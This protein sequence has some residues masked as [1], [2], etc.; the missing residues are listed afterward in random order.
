VNP[1]IAEIINGEEGARLH[2]LEEDSGIAID[3]QPDGSLGPHAMRIR[4]PEE[5]VPTSATPTN[6]RRRAGRNSG[7]T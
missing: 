3:L 1:R 5:P 7:A 6:R 4:T 2:W